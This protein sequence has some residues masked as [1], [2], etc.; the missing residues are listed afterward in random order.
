MSKEELERDVEDL[1][2]EIFVMEEGY[3]NLELKLT[4]A[5]KILMKLANYDCLLREDKIKLQA[6]AAEFL[7][8]N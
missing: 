3:R 8:K 2:A 6:E 4:A 1:S 7:Y 5:E